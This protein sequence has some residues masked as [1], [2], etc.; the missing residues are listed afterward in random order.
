MF[1]GNGNDTRHTAATATTSS[2][3]R[4][5]RDDT[6]IGGKGTDTAFLGA[7]N[8]TFIW[9]NGDGSDVVEGQAGFDTLVFN[10]ND[11][12]IVT[13]DISISANEG[14]A[15]LSRVQGDILMISTVSSV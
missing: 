15:T 8:D 3:A 12:P 13:E 5:W 10:G 9:N 14:R 6:V 1:G 4:P 11:N 7:G 2:T